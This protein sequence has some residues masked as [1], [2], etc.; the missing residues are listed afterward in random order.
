MAILRSELTAMYTTLRAGQEMPELSLLPI[1]Y[2]DF[3]AWQRSRLERDLDM[4]ARSSMQA[5]VLD[6]FAAS[7]ALDDPDATELPSASGALRIMYL[8]FNRRLAIRLNLLN[9]SL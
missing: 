6:V 1:Q 7:S 4:Q 2:T 3:A 9:F 8:K 5:D